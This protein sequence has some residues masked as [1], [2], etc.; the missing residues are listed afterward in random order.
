MRY[1]C[2]TCDFDGTIARDGIVAPSTREALNKVRASGRKL[3]LATGR[4]LDE[5]FDVFPNSDWFDRVV[6]E[7][8]A[9]LYR[10]SSKERVALAEPPPA[11]FVEE[12]RRRGVAPLSVGQCVVATWHPHEAIVLQ[13]IREMS[14]ELQIIFNKDAV[15]VL[16]SGVNK[17]TGLRVALKEM[18]LSPHNVVGVGDAEND[19]GLFKLCECRVAVGNALP[20][21]KESAD[22]VTAGTHGAGVEELIQLLLKNDLED[23]APRLNRHDIVL[24]NLENGK[25]F[26]LPVYGSG[27]LIMGPSG[28]GKSTTVAAIVDR[29]VSNKYQVCLFDPEGDYDEFEPLLSLGGPDHIPT[30]A[31][32]SDG[33]NNPTQSVSINLLGVPLADRPSFFQTLLVHVLE[34]RVNRGRPHWLVFDEAHHLLPAELTAAD[35]VRPKELKNLAL[36]TV[37]PNAVA[38]AMLRSLTGIIV[39]GKEPRTI[40]E[41]LN[42]SANTNYQLD[43]SIGPPQE[44][45]EVLTWLFS[46]PA[47]PRYVK[48]KLAESEQRRHRRKYA[49]GE[50]G[51]DKSFYFRGAQGK[52]NLRAHNMNLFTQ[53]AEGLDDE[54]WDFHLSK[55][56]YSRWLRDSIRDKDLAGIVATIERDRNLSATESR[57]QVIEA[58]RKNYTST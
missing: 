5:L 57:R 46:D 21:L 13:V 2:L 43:P 25:A 17:G 49:S 47:G 3:I 26:S 50:L 58:I 27:L 11:P 52:L 28:S 4:E 32:V 35:S 36:V 33:L 42:N 8:G 1:V 39:V 19:H 16:P 6:A 44:V 30:W 23:L 40:L 56:D 31:E 12:L 37:H 15:M 53:L 34:L 51:E 54:T 29:L 45:G 20:A 22:W 38:P 18:G 7:N 48:V 9:V 10:P 24:G 14:L 41:M 55:G